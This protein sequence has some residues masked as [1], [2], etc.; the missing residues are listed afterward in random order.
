MREF[1]DCCRA[2]CVGNERELANVDGLRYYDKTLFL[3]QCTS[4]LE[5]FTI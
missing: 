1:I 3:Y 4:V 5:D 2:A